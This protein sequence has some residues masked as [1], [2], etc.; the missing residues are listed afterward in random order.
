[1]PRDDFLEVAKQNRRAL[2]L[3]DMTVCVW[4]IIHGAEYLACHERIRV[5]IEVQL[6]FVIQVTSGKERVGYGFVEHCVL[7]EE[8]GDRLA[9]R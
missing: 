1:M 8:R 7:S 2:A 9:R 6:K 5:G 4:N 3:R